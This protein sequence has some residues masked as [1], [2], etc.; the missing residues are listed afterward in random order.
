MITRRGS[1]RSR[2][3]LYFAVLRLIQQDET[4]KSWYAKK[5]ARDGGVKMKAIIAIMR[6]LVKALWYVARGRDFDSSLMF[7]RSHLGLAA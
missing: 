4:V 5:G 1:G 3:W 2:R 7:D 6:K